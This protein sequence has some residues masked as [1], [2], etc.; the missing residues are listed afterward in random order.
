MLQLYLVLLLALRA[1]K[2]LEVLDI[3]HGVNP[4]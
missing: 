3:E 1:I 4:K 2:L